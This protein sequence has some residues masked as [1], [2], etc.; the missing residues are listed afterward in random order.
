MKLTLSHLKIVLRNALTFGAKLLWIE[1]D[2][3]FVTISVEAKLFIWIFSIGSSSFGISLLLSNKWTSI[4]M[5]PLLSSPVDEFH[6][7]LLLLSFSF[8]IKVRDKEN[9]TSL[10]F[11]Q[12]LHYL[13]HYQ[14]IYF[15]DSYFLSQCF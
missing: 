2:F 13:N 15:V 1:G 7:L 11:L 14:R 5:F 10:P 9:N 3:R 4:S 12:P 6:L 8:Y